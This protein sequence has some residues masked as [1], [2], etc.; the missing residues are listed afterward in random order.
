MRN[1]FITTAIASVIASGAF[2]EDNADPMGPTLSGEVE[3]KFAETADDK[4]GG[5]MALDLDINASGMATVDLDLSATDGNAVTLD[6]W[7]VGTGLAGIGIALG[8]DNGVMVEAENSTHGT[9]ATPAMTESL[10]VTVGD[11]TVAVGFTDW[12]KDI[13]DI[14]NIQ[15]AYTLDL[16][17]FTVTAAGDYNMDSENIVVG[18]AV[19]GIDLGIGTLGSALTYDVDNEK[20][21]YEI[22]GDAFGVTAY[23]NGDDAE[24]LQN[25]GGEYE[26]MIGGAELGTGVNYNIDKEEFSPTVTVGF[27]F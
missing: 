23:V 13:T 8:D 1:L 20:I 21:G 26:Y 17:R 6:S 5:A 24:M 3:L 4:W 12:T 22:V 10:A 15:G 27:N 11:A 19:G 2:A 25:I 14:S 7:T 18:G 9:L 16:G